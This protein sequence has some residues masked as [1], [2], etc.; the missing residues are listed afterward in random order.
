[1]ESVEHEWTEASS[2]A[3]EQGL[4]LEEFW[5]STPAELRLIS[6]GRMKRMNEFAVLVSWYTE[7]LSRIDR[8]P[9]LA[10]LLEDS[11]P[12]EEL[13]GDRERHESEFEAL[14]TSHQ[15]ARKGAGNGNG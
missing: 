3:L 4:S 9:S 6:R 10:T 11:K 15:S 8:L 13:S 14:W 2:R 7:A 5:N 1:M 12:Q